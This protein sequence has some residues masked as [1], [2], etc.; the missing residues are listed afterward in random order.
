[1]LTEADMKAANERRDASFM[2]LFE[3]CVDRML[4]A[5]GDTMRYGRPGAEYNGPK[6]DAAQERRNRHR[7][8]LLDA[9][10]GQLESNS[11]LQL[12]FIELANLTPPK[13]LVLE[14]QEV[15]PA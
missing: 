8:A 11:N 3:E 15:G 14:R 2:S 4:E 1:M 5:H 12:K 7:Q 9:V 6:H 13:P 10:K